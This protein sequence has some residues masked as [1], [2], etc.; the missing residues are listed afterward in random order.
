MQKAITNNYTIEDWIIE[1]KN[2]IG[3]GVS[4]DDMYPLSTYSPINSAQIEI[5]KNY[6]FTSHTSIFSIED[7]HQKIQQILNRIN[8]VSNQPYSFNEKYPEFEYFEQAVC[9]R[10]QFANDNVELYP[11]IEYHP[12]SNE[13][14]ELIK[15]E[16]DKQSKLNRPYLDSD[17]TSFAANIVLLSDTPLDILPAMRNTGTELVI[18]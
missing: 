10:S 7:F 5:I 14:S 11:N 3:L 8:S 16:Y 17:L 4:D 2:L 1:I 15:D 9:N 13:Q 18:S 6:Y 12:M